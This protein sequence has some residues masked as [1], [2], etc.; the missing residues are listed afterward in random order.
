MLSFFTGRFSSADADFSATSLQAPLNLA[1]RDSAQAQPIKVHL[2]VSGSGLASPSSMSSEEPADLTFHKTVAAENSD[3]SSPRTSSEDVSR[4]SSPDVRS[5]GEVSRSNSPDIA[6]SQVLVT[7]LQLQARAILEDKKIAVKDADGELYRHYHLHLP[8]V[9][10]NALYPITYGYTRIRN[11]VG[12]WDP[13]NRIIPNLYVGKLPEREDC[14]SIMS[15]VEASGDKLGLILSAVDYFELAGN[16]AMP[17]IATPKVWHGYGVRQYMLPMP[18][19]LADVND[20]AAIQGI[21]ALYQCIN[22]NKKAVYI[23]CKAGRGR[24]AMM[25]AIYLAIYH[26][27]CAGLEPTVALKKAIEILKKGRVHIEID[28]LKFN[29]ALAIITKL[30]ERKAQFALESESKSHSAVVNADSASRLHQFKRELSQTIAFK[31]LCIYAASVAPAVYGETIR[32]KNVMLM[33]ELIYK[34][35]NVEWYRDLTAYFHA[36]EQF[37]KALPAADLSK[38]IVE[39]AQSFLHD[40]TGVWS[41]KTDLAARYAL[42]VDFF[43]AINLS[44]SKYFVVNIEK[45]VGVAEIDKTPVDED[46]LTVERSVFLGT[47]K[48]NSAKAVLGEVELLEYFG[49]FKPFVDSGQ[50]QPVVGPIVTDARGVAAESLGLR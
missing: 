11:V 22:I 16:L 14:K 31:E 25:A 42:M 1:T 10:K 21:E 3:E 12:N 7:D 29:K 38:G 15:F 37:K 13:W 41:I 47:L 35:D 27:G 28:S 4:A 34:A 36:S 23:H 30:R 2:Q 9:T 18:D 46:Y 5:S 20:E 49:L 32:A 40:V 43:Q 26:D 19:F 45:V 33:L 44:I 6:P 17:T 8:T 50:T 39:N 24:S 48:P